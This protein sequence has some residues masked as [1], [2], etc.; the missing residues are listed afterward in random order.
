[1]DPWSK[2]ELLT[3]HPRGGHDDEEASGVAFFLWQGAETGTAISSRDQNCDGGGKEV[4]I[5]E[6]GS[7]P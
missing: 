1:M 6:K 2:V 5:E 7:V 4:G 3:H